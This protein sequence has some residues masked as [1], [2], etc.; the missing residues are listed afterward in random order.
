MLSNGVAGS[1][2]VVLIE[3]ELVGVVQLNGLLDRIDAD[4]GL[5][6]VGAILVTAQAVEVLVD[7]VPTLGVSERH[8][9]SAVTAKQ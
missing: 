6:A 9:G 1:F 2:E 8:L 3:A 7:L 5:L 4:K